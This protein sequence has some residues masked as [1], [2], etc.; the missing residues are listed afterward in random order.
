MRTARAEPALNPSFFEKKARLWTHPNPNKTFIYKVSIILAIVAVITQKRCFGIV[1][2][3]AIFVF[4]FFSIFMSGCRS[5]S[6]SG[7]VFSYDLVGFA[8]EDLDVFTDYTDSDRIKYRIIEYAEEDE[9]DFGLEINVSAFTTSG[10][11][12]V[13]YVKALLFTGDSD[14]NGY[15]INHCIG[16]GGVFTCVIDPGIPEWI[17]VTLKG[18]YPSYMGAG[19][20]NWLDGE[21]EPITTGIINFTVEH[22]FS[23]IYSS[24]EQQTYVAIVSWQQTGGSWP[25]DP[26]GMIKMKAAIPLPDFSGTLPDDE[27]ED[28][29]RLEKVDYTGLSADGNPEYGWEDAY[30]WE[31]NFIERHIDW[32]GFYNGE[33]TEVTELGSGSEGDQLTVSEAVTAGVTDGII[34]KVF[35][36]G[37]CAEWTETSGGDHCSEYL[38][39]NVPGYD[40]CSQ[41]SA[42]VWKES[43][44]Q[45]ETTF[46]VN[47]TFCIDDKGEESDDHRFTSGLV[48]LD[49]GGGSIEN[50]QR[51]FIKNY[52]ETGKTDEADIYVFYDPTN[53]TYPSVYG[54][55]TV[56]NSIILTNW[57]GCDIFTD[58]AVDITMYKCKSTESN[59]TLVQET[60]P[61]N[62]THLQVRVAGEADGD[63]DVDFGIC[64]Q[65]VTEIPKC[66]EE[67]IG[68]DNTIF[69][70]SATVKGDFGG[71]AGADAICQEEASAAGLSGTFKAWLSDSTTSASERLS[72]SS[73]AYF[74]PDGTEVAAN[75]DVLTGGTLTSAI[76]VNASG[77]TVTGAYVWTN[78]DETG[79]KKSDSLLSSCTDWTAATSGV[80]GR[81][82]D[83]SATDKKW[84]DSYLASCSDMNRFYCISEG[85]GEYLILTK[86]A[87]S[88]ALVNTIQEEDYWW[89]IDYTGETCDWCSV[90]YEGSGTCGSGTEGDVLSPSEA[91]EQGVKEGDIVQVFNF[92]T[93]GSW[94]N[95]HCT[96]E[97]GCQKFDLLV[98]K[99]VE[100][101]YTAGQLGTTIRSEVSNGDKV[102]VGCDFGYT[103]TGGG[104]NEISERD[105]D[106][107]KNYPLDANTWECWDDESTS[108]CYAVCSSAPSLTCSIKR[109]PATGNANQASVDV[110]CPTDTLVLGGGFFDSSSESKDQDQS[111]PFDEDTWHC[112]DDSNNGAC[113][114]I[115]C[116]G[117]DLE[118]KIE[119]ASLSA[120]DSYVD[121]DC[122]AGYI[123]TGGGFKDVGTSQGWDQDKN[124]PIDGDTWRCADDD[125]D[126]GTC[127]A[128][129]CKMGEEPTAGDDDDD[130]DD[131]GLTDL[132]YSCSF[133]GK[134]KHV[135]YYT[136]GVTF[137]S[138]AFP[139]MWITE[140]S[141][142]TSADDVT[143]TFTFDS[144][145]TP[146]TMTVGS[147][148]YGIYSYNSAPYGISTSLAGMTFK[149]GS[150][151]KYEIWAGDG[152]TVGG[153]SAGP[154][155]I[156]KINSSSNTIEDTSSNLDDSWSAEK[157]YVLLKDSTANA[158]TSTAIPTT[159]TMTQWDSY[160]Q[161]KIHIEFKNT[162]GHTMTLSADVAS[163]SCTQ[164]SGGSGDDD[165]DDDDSESLT[166]NIACSDG[167]DEDFDGCSGNDKLENI[168]F[169][170]TATYDGDLKA[171]A[172]AIGGYGHSGILGAH[173]L[174]QNQASNAGLTGTFKAWISTNT[175]HPGAF[176]TIPTSIYPYYL[177]NS[178]GEM[179]AED[180]DDLVDGEL[181]NPINVDASGS[182]VTALGNAVWTNTKTDGY[183]KGTSTETCSNWEDNDVAQ[184][185]YIGDLTKSDAEWTETEIP[186]GCNAQARLYCFSSYS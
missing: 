3:L 49:L 156:L 1:G 54:D 111:Y 32:C 62:L 13:I 72:E 10:E 103:L 73:N 95:N 158:L 124:Y 153:P 115:C 46:T 150:T 65:S 125:G 178:D 44:C 47:K 121:V 8:G 26:G 11:L 88:V 87:H 167:N 137:T 34:S 140:P 64:I 154:T 36:A 169:V 28:C 182:T 40:G 102:S 23:N 180:W 5:E 33:F 172:K 91:L 78:T 175:Q 184:Q 177:A 83:F 134:L 168:V 133:T 56:N 186:Q 160:A 141:T 155:D 146:T 6:V 75:W 22:N 179:I 55:E 131:T 27:V 171:A 16:P 81:V 14:D 176:N 2:L 127:Y 126:S 66:G 77:D 35:D 119:Q 90:Y 31:D 86:E 93:C 130:D 39:L 149:T 181:L 110:D 147:G 159:Y 59:A 4:I 71:L 53:N 94:Q 80:M 89:E 67:E 135:R 74:L 60:I 63:E 142:G 85:P 58:S 21:V 104:F 17:I 37:G 43:T 151:V 162:T 170:T 173:E 30:G 132:D 157:I 174:C 129:C 185:S 106:Q 29:F 48:T 122:S 166:G 139:G 117:D 136:N 118:C 18:T 145:T 19:I 51:I 116:S 15:D 92:G 20:T 112:K 42:L 123:V 109:N 164:G 183:K 45:K 61:F 144:T 97:D 68:G 105:D 114:A 100:C 70:T 120:T 76:N 107:D 24:D 101:V 113:Y 96:A 108:E 12:E 79:A 161:S 143:G 165:D 50:V 38:S 148:S 84:T 41:L 25:D 82:G 128:V 7:P 98:W 69:V 138:T 163:I 152:V 99:P 57:D 52:T 9:A